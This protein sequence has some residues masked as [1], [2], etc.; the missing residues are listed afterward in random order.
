MTT[1]QRTGDD[2]TYVMRGFAWALGLWAS[3]PFVLFLIYSGAR[4]CPKLSWSSPQGMP[5]FI[6]FVV[7]AVGVLIAWRWELIGGAIAVVCAIAINALVCLGSGRALF[8]AALMNSVP[9]FV[10]GIL[11][12][13]CYWRTRQTQL[14]QKT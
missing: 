6:I 8:Y 14:W 4:V 1:A 9:F 5:L 7:A 10:A 2:L 12:L 13:A 11:F 3:T